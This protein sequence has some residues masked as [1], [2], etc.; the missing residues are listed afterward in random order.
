MIPV[1]GNVVLVSE[2]V[3]SVSE[4]WISASDKAILSSRPVK[5]SDL[6]QSKVISAN[7]KWSETLKL[8]S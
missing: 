7:K 5:K 2:K 3:I 1:N 6:I 8:W 4:E